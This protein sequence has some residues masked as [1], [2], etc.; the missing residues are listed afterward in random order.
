[1]I[2]GERLGAAELASYQANVGEVLDRFH[3]HEGILQRIARGHDT[4]VG[5]R[6]AS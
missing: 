1:M 2:R 3:A 6:T 5:E 4:M